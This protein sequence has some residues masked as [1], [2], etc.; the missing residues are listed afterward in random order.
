MQQPPA[1]LLRFLWLFS[2]VG[3]DASFQAP[4]S[5][6]IF[7]YQR[8]GVI[9]QR[10]SFN[11]ATSIILFSILTVLA[12]F[13]AYYFLG[14]SIGVYC[15][16]ALL[17]LL[18]SHAFLVR[19]LSYESCFSY[20]LLNIFLCAIIIA[21]SYL[22][23]KDSL[24]AYPSELMIFLILNWIIPLLYCIIRNLTDR[25][26]KYTNFRIFYRNINLVFAVF[27][28]GILILVLFLKN[29]SLVLY[30]TDFQSVNLVPFLTLATLIEDYLNG[31]ASLGTIAIYLAQGIALFIPYGFYA[32]LLLR[33]QSRLLR[34]LV[35]LILPLL[36]EILQRVFLLGKG[37]LD[38]VILGFLGGIIGAVIYHILNRIY[39]IFT[40]EDFLYG[41]PH[42]PYSGSSLHF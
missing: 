24:Q 36:V 27:Y 25:S 33:Y 20:S 30:Y 42:R 1:G 7:Y 32:T 5:L 34:I 15:I 19:T 13:G 41:R 14:P 10:S 16:A 22:G 3:S 21:L 12:Q 17:S 23:N 31:Y 37:D 8:E 9:M 18:F 26:L 11:I 29:K 39:R 40:D 35:L 28:I 2:S 38:D 4:E 6:P